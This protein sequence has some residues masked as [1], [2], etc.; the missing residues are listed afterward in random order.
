MH[1][2]IYCHLWC[3]WHLTAD[4]L[5]KTDCQQLCNVSSL[6]S[7][8]GW[9]ACASGFSCPSIYLS[10]YLHWFTV[11][12]PAESCSH[13]TVFLSSGQQFWITIFHSCELPRGCSAIIHS[14]TGLNM[15][16]CWF[17]TVTKYRML[18]VFNNNK[19]SIFV[20][21]PQYEAHIG[22]MIYSFSPS[23]VSVYV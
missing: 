9:P 14:H 2:S 20:F 3:R 4:E 5:S 6:P 15:F 18:S 11:W 22:R 7:F 16:P 1:N 19:T 23:A 13:V 12:L 17:N 8:I 10:I 21:I